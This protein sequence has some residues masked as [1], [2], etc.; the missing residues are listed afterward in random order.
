METG[1][2]SVYAQK[3]NLIDSGHGS[4]Q[5]IDRSNDLSSASSGTS[6]VDSICTQSDSI[7]LWLIIIDFLATNLHL[8]ATGRGRSIRG[9]QQIQSDVPIINHPPPQF[10]ARPAVP[11]PAQPHPPP[12]SMKDTT[13]YIPPEPTDDE[14]EMFRQ[15]ISSGIHFKEYDKIPINVRFL[16]FMSICTLFAWL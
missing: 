10:P 3:P 4:D 12:P 6:S 13:P 7:W 11:K 1:C 5:T 9:R 14:T 16:F 15:G 2:W 8:Q